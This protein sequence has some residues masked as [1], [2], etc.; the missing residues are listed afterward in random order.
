MLGLDLT[1]AL[2]PLLGGNEEM[3]MYVKNRLDHGH[4]HTAPH[5]GVEPI[6]RT[7]ARPIP[8]VGM[9]PQPH[10]NHF[11]TPKGPICVSARLARAWLRGG[12]DYP[13]G[14]SLC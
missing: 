11:Q 12:T 14:V 4:S 10:Q 9:L 13:P 7:A 6:R 3:N 8:V 2:Q 1:D 5:R